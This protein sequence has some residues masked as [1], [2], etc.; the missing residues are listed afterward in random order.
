[1]ATKKKPAKKKKRKML[2]DGDPPIIVG[3]GGSCYIWVNLEQ[4][5][6]PVNP[7]SDSPS[8]G[9]KPGAPKPRTRAAYSCARVTH[10]PDQIFFFDGVNGHTLTIQDSK[11]WF[12]SVE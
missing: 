2:L 9:I 12:I 11:T 6:R 10:T 7:Q 5:E 3:G 1:M 8:I 4:S